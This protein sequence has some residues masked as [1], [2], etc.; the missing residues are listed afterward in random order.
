MNL[1]V[2]VYNT[3]IT[4]ITTGIYYRG[5]PEEIY[6]QLYKQF[7]VFQDMYVRW[8]PISSFEYDS[9]NIHDYLNIFN[10]MVDYTYHRLLDEKITLVVFNRAPHMGG[11]Y[12]LSLLAETM[13][14]RTLIMEPSIIPNRFFYTFRNDDFGNFKTCHQ[15]YEFEAQTLEKKIDKGS[16]LS[17]RNP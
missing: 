7:Q 14:I 13:G 3:R 2:P 17:A 9:R 5:V 6:D 1:N 4:I 10:M 11:D 8:S 16:S 12:I 15:L